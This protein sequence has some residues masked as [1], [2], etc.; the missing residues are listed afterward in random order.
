MAF[1]REAAPN[2]RPTPEG[3]GEGEEREVRAGAARTEKARL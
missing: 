2:Y 3:E 1:S